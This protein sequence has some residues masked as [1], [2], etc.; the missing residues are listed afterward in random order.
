MKTL[1]FLTI[2]RL[3]ILASVAAFLRP[4]FSQN[5]SSPVQLSAD[6]AVQYAIEGNIGLQ[7]E[8]ISLKTAKRSSSTS[9]NALLPSVN[10]TGSVSGG[11]NID[12]PALQAGI[13]VSLGLSPSVYTTVKAASLAYQKQELDWESAVR[14]I[15]LNVRKAYYK[16]LYEKENLNLMQ[17]N[18]SSALRQY[19]SNAARYNRG[20][21]ARLDVLSAQVSYQNAQV[22]YENALI[23]LQTDTETF[24]QMLGLDPSCEIELTLSLEPLLS[25]S[26]IT[27]E[28]VSKLT[29]SSP[30]IAS[31]EKQIE[32]AKNNL[33]SSRFSAWGPTLTGSYSYTM[34][35]TVDT[36]I[37]SDSGT[38]KWS[39]GVTIPLDGII[40]FSKRGVAVS[41]QKDTL[42]SLELEL[43]NT[44][45]TFNMNVDSCI[46]K[47]NYSQS[48]INLRKSSVNLAAQTYNMSLDAYN[49][50]SKDLLSLQSA[51]D[52]LTQAKVNLHS[53]AYNLVC[54]ILDLENTLG[55]PFGTLIK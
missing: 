46:R 45:N 26:E 33:L 4:A 44:K 27:K 20:G 39:L 51:L 55:V 3:F 19:N 40:P 38:G 43:E 25:L 28:D 18:V 42:A 6:Q 32:I 22:A 34:N 11:D 49:R 16:L 7:R 8:K 15:E 9:L 35:G 50:G 24:K 47:I 53:E 13:S 14:T 10:A 12:D 21:L 23:T 5:E 41:D 17:S 52:S 29:S 1:N 54:N 31:L 30:E 2:K 48:V 36:G 37:D